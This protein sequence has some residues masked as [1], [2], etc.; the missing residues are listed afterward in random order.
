MLMKDIGK[1]RFIGTDMVKKRNK[2]GMT[3]VEALLAVSLVAVAAA[4]SAKLAVS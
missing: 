4:G 3:V 2:Q 1:W